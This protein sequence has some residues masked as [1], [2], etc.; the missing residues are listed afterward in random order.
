MINDSL[1]EYYKMNFNLKEYYHYSIQE[2]DM[3]LPW[4]RMVYI[5]QVKELDKKRED[6]RKK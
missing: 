1:E 6:A 3:M 4:E 5:A 2:L